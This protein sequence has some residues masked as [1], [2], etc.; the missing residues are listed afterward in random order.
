[1]LQSAPDGGAV[2]RMETPAEV[3]VI[4]PV[5][6]LYAPA[7]FPIAAGT[8]VNDSTSWPETKLPLM[9]TAPEV[10]AGSGVRSPC[11]AAAWGG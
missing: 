5:A 3:S 4:T 6:A 8:L 11:R 1:M 9:D 10:S 7:M 2:A